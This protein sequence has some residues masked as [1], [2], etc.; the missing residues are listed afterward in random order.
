MDNLVK[1]FFELGDATESVWAEPV[2]GDSSTFVIRNTPFFAK[3]VSFLDTVIADIDKDRDDVFIFSRAKKGSGHSTYRI[4][5]EQISKTF[6][7]YWKKLEK[8]GCSY[9]SASYETSEGDKILYAIDVPALTDIYAV[10][11]ILEK[12]EKNGIWIFE[13]GHCGHPL[14]G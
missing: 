7:S 5:I 10:Y 9:E 1:I 14:K 8:L 2:S 4:I 6:L 12:G 11:T 13:E 3:G